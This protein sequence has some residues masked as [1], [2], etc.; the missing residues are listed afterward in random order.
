MWS[1]VIGLCDFT[2][3]RIWSCFLLSWISLL[4]LSVSSWIYYDAKSAIMQHYFHSKFSRFYVRHKSLKQNDRS[5][6]WNTLFFLTFLMFHN[7]DICICAK[8]W[9]ISFSPNV[10]H[11][12]A[13]ETGNRSIPFKWCFLN[14]LFIF[15]LR[16]L[17]PHG[18]QILFLNPA[19]SY[20]QVLFWAAIILCRTFPT[21][22]FATYSLTNVCF[23]TANRH[24]T[25][26][27]DQQ[28]GP[29]Q[30]AIFCLARSDYSCSS[31]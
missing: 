4:L 24:P 19:W 23:I 27:P 29:A 31:T 5:L 16:R 30:C 12:S 18:K 2:I 17:S 3:S 26:M 21:V 6:S 28:S 20:R 14:R 10:H 8:I 25:K 15:F 11:I 1:P 7:Q 22:F 13:L 9:S